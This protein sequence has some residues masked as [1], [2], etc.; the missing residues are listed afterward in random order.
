MAKLIMTN[1]RMID[2]DVG[3]SLRKGSNLEVEMDDVVMTRGRT[4]FE[5]RDTPSLAQSLGLPEDTPAEEVVRVIRA[6]QV[7][8]NEQTSERIEALKGSS[9]WTYI[10]RSANAATVIEGLFAVAAYAA[11]IG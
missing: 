1:I 8:P 6:L 2:T 3:V 9:I 5:E 10:E 11:T 4:L 7:I